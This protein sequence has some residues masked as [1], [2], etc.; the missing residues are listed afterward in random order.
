MRLVK[1]VRG[2]RLHF[3]QVIFIFPNEWNVFEFLNIISRWDD[4]CARTLIAFS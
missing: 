2:I 3:K 1:H 4:V